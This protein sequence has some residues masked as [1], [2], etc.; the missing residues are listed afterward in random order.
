MPGRR[1]HP[2]DFRQR[3]YRRLADA[4]MPGELRKETRRIVFQNVARARAGQIHRAPNPNAGTYFTLKQDADILSQVGRFSRNDIIIRK[5]KDRILWRRR[6]KPA[7]LTG[8]YDTVSWPH[9]AIDEVEHWVNAEGWD[10]VPDPR[11][12]TGSEADRN[13]AIDFFSSPNA[14]GDYIEDINGDMV[15]DSNVQGDHFTNLARIEGS[16][17]IG[18]LFTMDAESTLIETDLDGNI[19]AYVMMDPRTRKETARIDKGNVMQFRRNA[20]GRTLFGAS[21][22]K[23]LLLAVEADLNGQVWNRDEFKNGNASRRAWIFPQDTSDDSMDL[24]ETV[25]TGARG[26]GGTHQDIVL[27]AADGELKI[28]KLNTTPN[29]MEYSLLRKTSRDEYLAV[30]GVPPML[31]GIIEAGN[32][33]GGTGRDQIRKFVR[34]TVMPIQHRIARL[35][36]DRIMKQEMGIQGWI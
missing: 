24:N 7:V 16:D 25:I 10:I 19:T 22:F 15:V 14:D 5:S 27:R 33:G 1:G 8:I 17:E 21:V 28:H 2:D 30:I 32:I 12:P 4:I 3:I 11:N 9:A 36:T 18:G 20:R 34:G 13:R 6:L 35:F 23:P 26:P 29:D 31:L